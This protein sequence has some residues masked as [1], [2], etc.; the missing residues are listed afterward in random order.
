MGRR[1]QTF[2]PESLNET[3]SKLKT[4][5]TVKRHTRENLT[6]LFPPPFMAEF[7]NIT[8]AEL[9]FENQVIHMVFNPHKIQSPKV[10]ANKENSGAFQRR[11]IAQDTDI[12]VA[13]MPKSGT[14]WLKAVAFSV[15]KRHIYGP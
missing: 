4:R 7:S 11:F 12:I 13:S 3:A 15:A 6:Y 5:M 8:A 10:W 9:K 1:K 2:E 14:T